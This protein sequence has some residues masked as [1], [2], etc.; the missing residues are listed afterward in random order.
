MFYHK[1]IYNQGNQ[2]YKIK[3]N[4]SNKECNPIKLFYCNILGRPCGSHLRLHEELILTGM[5]LEHC[6]SSC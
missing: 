2:L 5:I 6:G 3:N 4:Q 1:K